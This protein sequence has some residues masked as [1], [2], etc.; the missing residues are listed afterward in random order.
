MKTRGSER[1]STRAGGRTPARGWR[2]CPAS[3]RPIPRGGRPA[4]LATLIACLAALVAAPAHA[5]PEA[6]ILRI[7]PRASQADGAPTLT[8]VIELVQTKK[9]AAITGPCAALTG[10]A[11]LDCIA[12]G[13]QKDQAL[14][15]PIPFLEEHA[16]FT[17]KV[18]NSEIPAQFVSHQRWGDSKNEPG[19]GTAWL[20]LIDAANSMG[21][22]INDAKAVA[23]QFIQ[24]M[25]PNDIVD[26]MF[27]N[28]RAVV[29]DSGWTGDKNGALQA[30]AS[31]AG[32]YPAQGRVRRLFSIVK[33][34]ATDGFKEL[35]NTGQG[36]TVPMHQAM[37]VL[38]NGVAGADASS[39]GPGAGLLSEY[40]S[41]GRF[42]EDNEALPKSPVPVVSVWFPTPAVEEFGSNARDFM[43][44]LSNEEIG[45]NFSIIREGQAAQRAPRIQAAVQK[46]FDQM[47]IVKWKVS[48]VASTLSQSFNLMFRNTQPAIAPDASFQNVPVGIDP[49]T[50]PLDIDVEATENWAKKNPIYPGGSVKVFGNFCWGGNAQRAELYM[51]P[52]KQSAPASL[53]G[54][55]V[56]DAKKAQRT[57]IEAGMRGKAISAGDSVVEFEIPDTTKFLVGKGEKFTA[58][59][60]VY[61]NQARRTSAVTAEKILTLR[62]QE[63]PLPYLLIGGATFGGVVLLLLLVTLVRAGGRNRRGGGG[64]A[65]PPKP[66]V[67][68]P[69]PG[70]APAP[71]P[72]AAAPLPAPAVVNQATLSGA[73][74]IFTILP[75]ME[76]KAGRDG[77]SCQILLTEP[78]VSGV[79]ASLKLVGGQ[80]YAR[81]DNS[82]N[83]THVGGQRLTPGVW[84]PVPNGS[85]LRFGPVE[86]QVRLE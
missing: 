61:D 83:G 60:I 32:T 56:E 76:M 86:F 26:V 23:T 59:L 78:R 64:G 18:D 71:M 49:T 39:T 84:S 65:P 48:C 21:G 30:I 2:A 34:A 4:A 75:G 1:S 33:Q 28:D 13:L 40:M 50:W 16:L 70:P 51:V 72:M 24:T 6:H 35:G 20:I 63:K 43:E 45:G 42:P 3:S 46:R 66:I 73:Q 27:F 7:D 17:I 67:A 53:E 10:D 38:S 36:F 29:K 31:V 77:A 52:K 44:N 82:N 54:G 11:N 15:E 47:H 9:M 22:R 79:H 37:V 8:T 62:A 5:A 25:G 81:D 85:T 57:L 12:D 69:A 19:V 41:K 68:G 80:L 74:G 55:T 58:R 14:Y